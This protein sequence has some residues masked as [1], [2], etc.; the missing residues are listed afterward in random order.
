MT[1][2][3]QIRNSTGV[4]VADLLLGL[5]L[6][7]AGES[8]S[9]SGNFNSFGYYGFV[10]DDW[11]VSPRLTL[12]LGFRYEFNTRYTEVQNRYSYFDRQFPGGRLLLAGTSQAFI[13]PNSIV[14]GPNTPRGLYPANKRDLGPRIGLAFRPFGDNRTAIRAGYGVFYWMVDGQA[15]RQ[16]E[17]NPPNGKIISLNADQNQN[18]SSP[19]AITVTNLFPPAGTPASQPSIYTDIAARGDPAIQ[20]WSF[21][22]QRQVYTDILVELGYLGSHGV[23]QVYY[24]QGNQARLDVNPASPTPIL[25]RRPFPLWGSS[26]RTTGGDGTTSYHGSYVKLEKRFSSG[27][28]FL[29]HYTLGKALD[30]SSQVNETT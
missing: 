11:K 24:S 9:L 28:S 8:T 30:Y 17:R 3:P 22:L 4:S 27:L 5:P 29:T 16:L 14:P 2:N 26:M 23:H 10:Q 18:S 21:S 20:Q 12:N 1:Q 6:T 13:A 19:G 7:A 25:S 15:T